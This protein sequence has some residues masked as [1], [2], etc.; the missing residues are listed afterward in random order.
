MGRPVK[1]VE[2][3]KADVRKAGEDYAI[4]PEWFDRVGY[5]ADIP[6]LASKYGIR[7]IA[8]DEWAKLVDWGT[9]LKNA[10]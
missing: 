3:P 6:T 2:T 1:F 10:A 9:V 4:M 5:N 8:L 7:P